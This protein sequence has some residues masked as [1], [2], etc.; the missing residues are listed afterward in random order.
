MSGMCD[1]EPFFVKYVVNASVTGLR[2]PMKGSNAPST[3]HLS[4]SFDGWSAVGVG[5]EKSR[6]LWPTTNRL[7]CFSA[8]H[9]CGPS[10]FFFFFSCS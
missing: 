2:A 3:V 4:G 9:E 8:M 1:A 6:A 7:V 10:S 5:V